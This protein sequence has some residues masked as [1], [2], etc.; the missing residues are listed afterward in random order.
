MAFQRTHSATPGA[1]SEASPT[2]EWIDHLLEF[3]GPPAAFLTELLSVQCR[4]SGA[5]AGAVF[6]ATPAGVSVMAAWPGLDA[7]GKAPAWLMEAAQRVG[8]EGLASVQTLA[9]HRDDALYGQPAER[10]AVLTPLRR[11]AQSTYGVAAFLVETSDAATL[12][13]ARE[14]LELTGALLTLYEM[15]LS[16]RQR[17]ADVARLRSGME[18]LAAVNAQRRFAGAAMAACNE[19]ASRWAC[20][21]VA[22]GFLK[23]RY[24]RL[25]ALSHTEK[26]S[27][28]MKL[29]QDIES[30]MEE[31]LDQDVEVAHPPDAE[32][33]YVCRA[34]GELSEHHGRTSVL[35]LPLRQDDKPIGV[36]TV[37]R[38]SDKPV[39]ADETEALRLT[40]D[41]LT[42]RVADLH[43]TDRWFGARAAS[44]LRSGLAKLVG[45][46]H[47]WLKLIALGVCAA[48]AFLV[49]AKGTYTAAGTFTLITDRHEV[50]AAPYDGFLADVEVEP[51]DGV[52]AGDALGALETEDLQRQLEGARLDRREALQKAATA[53]SEGK[54][55]EAQIAMT[56]A[57]KAQTQI[58]QFTADIERA[59]MRAPF[60]GTVISE[61][62][63]QR[64]DSRVERGKPLFEVADLD[65]IYAEV[66]IPEDQIAE[67]RPGQRGELAPAA[68][69]GRKVGFV[70]ERI[71]PVAEVV[72]KGN[73]FKVRLKLDRRP[74][75]MRPGMEG[76]AKVHIDRRSYAWLWSRRLVNWI[77]MKL[78]L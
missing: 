38:A 63:R 64:R 22:M 72:E 54:I 68:F 6:R 69:P 59:A 74:E 4:L 60:D 76:V 8:Q 51:G 75:W 18:V 66:A 77:R 56:E 14:K 17:D 25:K 12:Q 3:D 57:E 28:K 11:G 55:A 42:P 9:L 44:A 70:V 73:V 48:I 40:A 45:P 65:A 71:R 49:F 43:H 15:R 50:V 52:E 58:D 1:S 7:G 20:E 33:T 16:L 5:S 30:A 41:L 36:L 26:F 34:A 35:S 62:L 24:V 27:R 53:R 39:T 32:A 46:K 78:W 2:P 31:C 10:H 19:I 21:R 37:E 47:T 61:S 29:V 67:V 23:G 13:A